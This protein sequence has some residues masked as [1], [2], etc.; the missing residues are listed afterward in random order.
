MDSAFPRAGPPAGRVI[1]GCLITP[2][3]AAM[4]E[5]QDFVAQISKSRTFRG[6]WGGQ[7]DMRIDISI[8][9]DT[10]WD[11]FLEFQSVIKW[12]FCV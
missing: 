3:S 4:E 1:S 7:H 10:H 6:A 12:I 5:F 9:D 11:D 8:K 2:L